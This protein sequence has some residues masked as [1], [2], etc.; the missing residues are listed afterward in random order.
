MKNAIELAIK[1]GF[2]PQ[3]YGFTDGSQELYGNQ[4]EIEGENEVHIFTVSGREFWI[5]TTQITS[6]PLF[7]QA[8]GK[9]MG[10]GEPKDRFAFDADSSHKDWKSNWHRFIDHLA[11]GKD[12][13]S[14]FS[15]IS[16]LEER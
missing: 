4:F 15:F 5:H 6:D 16:N 8:L 2:R 12:V 11:E 1:G 7:W 10:W 14:F 13:E 9:A 3:D